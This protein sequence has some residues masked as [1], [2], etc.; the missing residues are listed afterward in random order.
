MYIRTIHGILGAVAFLA[1][2]PLG[3]VIIRII[4][5]RFTIWIHA[6]VQMCGYAANIAC[7]GLG[8][9]LTKVVNIRG[10]TLVSFVCPLFAP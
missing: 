8:I 9:Y 10:V 6:L 5:G 3:S 7:V 4:P 1:V 2:F